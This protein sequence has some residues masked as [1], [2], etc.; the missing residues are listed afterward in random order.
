MFRTKQQKQIFFTAVGLAAILVAVTFLQPTNFQYQNN[1]DYKKLAAQDAADQAAYIKYLNSIQPDPV[2]SRDIFEKLITE[3]D[4]RAQ[5]EKELDVKQPITLPH[6][7]DSSI[8][9]GKASGKEAAVSYFTAVGSLADNFNSQVLDTSKTLFSQD[10][11]AGALS[12]AEAL[13]SKF[14]ADLQKTSVPPEAVNFHKAQLGALQ[15]YRELVQTAGKYAAEEIQSP[16]P[17]VYKN[18]AIINEEAA[19][20]NKEFSKLD[21]K[22][23]LSALP[24][25]TL[26]SDIAGN[27]FAIVKTANAQLGG[28]VVIGNVP[29]AVEKAIREGLASAFANFIS[30]YL[31]K[32]ITAIESNYKIANFLYY[33]DAVIRGQYVNDYLTKYVTNPL[34]RQLVTRFIPQFNCGQSNESLKAVFKAKAQTYLGYDPAKVSPDD[35]Q[36]AQKLARAGNFLASSEGWDLTLKEQANAALSAAEKAVNQELA[37][38]GLKSPRDLVNRQIAV[39]L[40]AVAHSESASLSAFMN[41]GVVNVDKVV[42]KIVSSVIQNLF[43]KFLFKG[44]VVYKEQSACVAVPQLQPVIPASTTEYHAPPTPDQG[45]PGHGG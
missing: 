18:Y 24:P 10:S 26:A 40:N 23:S 43:D 19:A 20:V 27:S 12:K 30:I 35:P 25:Q 28:I 45:P 33:T 2:A 13:T 5:I 15:N 9:V 11:S 22:Y 42:G 36:F 32:L 7:A 3:E 31:N 14:I 39:S 16:W 4:V 37:S 38:S 29:E 8:V 44:A 6:I 41:L 17:Q 34:D 1:T 21:K